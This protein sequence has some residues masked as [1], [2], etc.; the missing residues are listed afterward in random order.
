LIVDRKGGGNASG[1]RPQEIRNPNKSGKCKTKAKRKVAGG[2]G[3]VI[4]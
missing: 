2:N 4:S 3:R 1:E